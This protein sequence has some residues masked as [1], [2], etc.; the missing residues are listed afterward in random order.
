MRLLLFVRLEKEKDSLAKGSKEIERWQ[1]LRERLSSPGTYVAVMSMSLLPA[2]GVSLYHHI[3]SSAWTYVEEGDSTIR[4]CNTINFRAVTVVYTVVAALW[5][6]WLYLQLKQARENFG[7][8]SMYLQTVVTAVV[9]FVAWL[10]L[11]TLGLLESV[12]PA[13]I[14]TNCWI[15]F[16]L[17]VLRRDF[18]SWQP[19]AGE[20]QH[21]YESSPSRVAKHRQM[22]K[23][24]ALSMTSSAADLSLAA[25]LADPES[26][27]AFAEFLNAEFSGENMLFLKALET[28]RIAPSK[29]A[30][31]EIY[32]LY[33]ADTA[34]L[35]LNLSNHVRKHLKELFA[36]TQQLV[37]AR[38]PTQDVELAL[39]H[40]PDLGRVFDDAEAEI[41]TLL[42]EDSLR[43][44]AL[45][46]LD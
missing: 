46:N 15:F 26:R 19:T 10:F 14:A 42:Q 36:D 29:D 22:P 39:L 3:S 41:M 30:G 24:R 12:L 16:S 32:A 33:I 21:H 23:P 45:H 18:R 35:Q 1:R 9:C 7:I 5:I 31:L 28:F 25:V 17:S 4:H 11:S 27:K 44:F 2:A 43:R 38:A 34:P 6:L 37:L 40:A 20:L 8:K 13:L